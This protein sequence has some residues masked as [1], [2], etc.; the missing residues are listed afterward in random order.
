MVVNI[1]NLKFKNHKHR[2]KKVM[3]TQRNIIATVLLIIIY[4]V[5]FSSPSNLNI[6]LNSNRT[7]KLIFDYSVYNNASSYYIRNISKGYH[8]VSV[9]E[10][11]NSN[12]NNHNNS[13]R[14]I[15]S[16]NIF[17][18]ANKNIEATVG[19][20]VG[21]KII[22][23][24]PISNGNYGHNSYGENESGNNGN[25]GENHYNDNNGNYYGMGDYEFNM[26]KNTIIAKSFDS[27]KM[28][29][30][31]AALTNNNITSR[32][33]YEIAKLFSFDSSKLEIAKYAYSRTIDKGNYF[34]VN[35]AFTFSSSSD[36]LNR[37][38]QNGGY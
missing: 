16:G 5:A 7:F 10:K 12:H 3:K 6:R 26:L 22:R 21:Y 33:S 34:L 2:R 23:E 27:S 1:Q 15:F 38:I 29:T 14:L 19:K 30:A 11:S 32:Q 28:E 9:Y 36:E 31:K 17:I 25:Y 4:T 8:I 37:F 20:N 13:D 35:N 18:P 24:T